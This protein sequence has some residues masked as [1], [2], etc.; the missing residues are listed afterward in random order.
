LIQAR[1]VFDLYWLI[2]SGVNPGALPPRLKARCREAQANALAV[3]FAVFKS[4]VLAYLS[5]DHQS[6]YDSESVWEGMVL[7]VVDALGEPGA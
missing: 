5:P 6:Q 1:D 7:S 4:Q 2:S 3:T